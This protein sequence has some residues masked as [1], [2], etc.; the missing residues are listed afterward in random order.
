MSAPQAASVFAVS[1][2]FQAPPQLVYQAW[3][4]VAQLPMWFGCAGMTFRI[5]HADIRTGGSL[6]ACLAGA[7]GSEKWIKWLIRELIPGERIVFVSCY[8]DANGGMGRLEGMG[9]WPQQMLT[10]ID[11]RGD[12][13][14]TILEVCVTPHE[15]TP[16]ECAAF[17]ANSEGMRGGWGSSFDLL[18]THLAKELG[19]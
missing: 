12:G 10:A 15:A 19:S 1:R 9:Q 7:D 5:K 11:L 6:L 8:S 17:H 14:G 18:D 3:T 4:D 16:A 13:E 2:R